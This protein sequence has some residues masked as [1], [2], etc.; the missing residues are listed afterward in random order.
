MTA[1][2]LLAP[3]V[4][5]Q[6][7]PGAPFLLAP[8]VGAQANPGLFTE[9]PHDEDNK[10]R[11]QVQALTIAPMELDDIPKSDAV[12]ASL[13]RL[14]QPYLG[15]LLL[16]KPG[17]GRDDT[18]CDGAFKVLGVPREH[19]NRFAPF[20]N[21]S[22]LERSLLQAEVFGDKS[23][24]AIKKPLS[25]PF[26]L[27]ISH[28]VC[29][30]RYKPPKRKVIPIEANISLPVFVQK[31]TLVNPHKDN[32][33]FFEIETNLYKFEQADVGSEKIVCKNVCSRTL[34]RNRV[35]FLEIYICCAGPGHFFFGR[36]WRWISAGAGSGSIVFCGF[37]DLLFR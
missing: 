16:D 20:P 21:L 12:M 29:S 28:D 5:A 10:W 31:I 30:L 35:F 7:N 17:Y 26:I 1:P 2:F 3:G 37:R 23:D 32:D 15:C 9:D 4:G 34:S 27:D 36:V 33:S 22:A 13:R 25:I 19:V 18:D 14:P 6:A 11:L 24:G 8:G